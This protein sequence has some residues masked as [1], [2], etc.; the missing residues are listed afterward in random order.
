MERVCFSAQVCIR[1]GRNGEKKQM[2][3]VGHTTPAGAK[4]VPANDDGI[5]EINGWKFY[6]LGWQPD[7]FDAT[8]FI[9]GMATKDNLKP[10]DRKGCLDANHLRAH[11]L[12]T[13]RMKSHPFFFLQLLLPICDP[14][15][16]RIDG[17]GRMPFFSAA[18]IHTNEFAI[19]EKGW[20]GG[21]G[22]EF[23]LM[24]EQ[25]LVRWVGAP[26]WHGMRDGSASSLHRRWLLDDA[27]YNNIIANNMTLTRWRQIKGVF[28]LNNNLTTPG[29]GK[30]GYNP[31]AKYDL[32]ICTLC[33]N[34]NYFTLW[35]ELDNAA[36][37][38][39]WGFGGYMGNAGGWLMNKPV[40][41]GGQTAMLFDVSWRYP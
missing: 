35:A 36:D 3:Y 34:M 10:A 26:I 27:D 40:G 4:V 19:M 13:K 30:E 16:S 17:D 14:K 38:S 7:N 12:M 29:R 18:T 41:K 21:Y 22:H 2:R 23:K 6:Y 39:T 37:E 31:A 28:K 9:R 32:I 24:T 8:T 15:R 33:H 5:R 25:D 1:K 11:W 20:G